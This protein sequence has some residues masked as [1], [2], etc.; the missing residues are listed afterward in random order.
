MVVGGVFSFE[1]QVRVVTGDACEAGVGFFPTF[2]GFE[3][4][5]L[6]ANVGNASYFG[7]FD[8]PENPV[9]SAAEID[10]VGRLKFLG[11]ED[12]GGSDVCD[13]GQL[14]RL[15]SRSMFGAW[16]M[17]SLAADAGHQIL[18]VEQS[19]KYGSGG[20]AG[21]ALFGLRWRKFA[22]HRFI[23]V[24]RGAEGATGGKAQR[25]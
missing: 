23:Y 22:I 3:P 15:H 2:T 9:A 5:G 10:G 25:F 8:V 1:R 12:G 21:E 14:G 18:L 19:V 20:M 16:T 13:S 24:F 11:I 4:V 6:R 17:T 7:D